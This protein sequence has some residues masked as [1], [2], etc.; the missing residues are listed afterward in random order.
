M[1]Q[2][3]TLYTLI[4]C[5]QSLKIFK[6][7]LS[8]FSVS[9]DSK[10][11]GLICFF[12]IFSLLP[13]GFFFNDCWNAD[14][15]EIWGFFFPLFCRK[16]NVLFIGFLRLDLLYWDLGYFSLFNT[17]FGFEELEWKGN[18]CLHV[19]IYDLFILEV[20]CMWWFRSFLREVENY[21][22]FSLYILLGI[23]KRCFLSDHLNRIDLQWMLRSELRLQ[24]FRF[25]FVG[26]TGEASL[27]SHWGGFVVDLSIDIIVCQGIFV[28]ISG[29]DV[30]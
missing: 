17:R 9:E 19:C 28:W 22:F 25:Q 29:K 26:L 14:L 12:N 4:C 10:F 6:S 18:C 21:L 5:F 11:L 20:K 16:I 15:F 7:I 27:F 1:L 2:I 30:A 8:S 3:I 23:C 24:R 13:F